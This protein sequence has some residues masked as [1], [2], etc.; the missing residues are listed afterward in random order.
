VNIATAIE[1]ARLQLRRDTFLETGD[2]KGI[3]NAVCMDFA[4]QTGVLESDFVLTMGA[5]VAEY[6]VSAAGLYR[7][8]EEPM[9]NATSIMRMSRP[10]MV[11]LAGNDLTTEGTPTH[12]YPVSEM[13]YAL[14]PVPDA[15][16]E[17][18]TMLLHGKAYPPEITSSTDSNESLPFE[19]IDHP[20]LVSGMVMF[21]ERI[22]RDINASREVRQDYEQGIMKA[23][24]RAS[25]RMPGTA[26]VRTS[27]GR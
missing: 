9:F 13:T 4:S 25:T 3:L 6:D 22:D 26:R 11:V 19:V 15:S 1:Q 7:L 16:M 12:I 17:G 14:Y 23:R 18:L 21:A 5:G 2:W 27:G 24:Y 8:T 20:R 10:A